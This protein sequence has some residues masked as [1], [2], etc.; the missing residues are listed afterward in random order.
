MSYRN[1]VSHFIHL[2]LVFS[3]LLLIPH[4]TLANEPDKAT[5]PNTSHVAFAG[6]GWRAHIGH[7]AWTMALLQEKDH[8]LADAFANVGT[9]SSNSGGS[10]YSTMLMFSPSFN[11]AIQQANAIEK[12]PENGA[13]ATGWLGQQKRLFEKADCPVKT[14]DL[15][16]I[17][18]FNEY[19]GGV[20]GAS[21]WHKVIANL[22]Y[23]E[24]PIDSK[25]NGQRQAW[26]ANKT[27]LLAASMLTQQAVIS[28]DGLD[29]Q[30]YQACFA[31]SKPKTRGSK[32]ARCTQSNTKAVVSPVT[33]SSLPADSQDTPLP[34]FRALKP[35]QV[36]NVGYSE[37]AY[38]LPKRA[39]TQ[40]A[41]PVQTDTLPVIVAASA[42]SAA[43]GFA[44][45]KLVS[46]SWAESLLA[47]DEAIN[48][49]VTGGLEHYDAHD[50]SVKELA[51]KKIIQ[52]ADG[53]AVDNSAVAQ[54]VAYLQHNEKGHDFNIVAFDNVQTLFKTKGGIE[55]GVDFANLFGEGVWN[56]DQICSGQNGKGDCVTTPKLQVFEKAALD[57]AKLTWQASKETSSNSAD[58]G[59]DHKKILYT[60][61]KV[62]TVENSEYGIKGGL[63]GT[64][65]AFTAAWSDANTAPKNSQQ[66]FD[67][68]AEMLSFIASG[69]QIA[70]ADGVKGIQYLQN[71]IDGDRSH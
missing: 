39:K 46:G 37:A 3:L 65:H 64:L 30:Y 32:G 23:R 18:V 62:T 21:Y 6:G 55:I 42:S 34:F 10:W 14:G 61:L 71:A 25:L 7:S 66:D 17:C 16:T 4:G 53:G 51:S 59:N 54:L 48:F 22:V 36:F 45:S 13:T 70:G 9:I 40:L 43:T 69:L 47:S 33:F 28:H 68:Y 38:F 12:W 26:A 57:N 1:L 44:A 29:E 35:E 11:D 41:N 63:T 67:A 49:Q 24:T 8:S 31:P 58:A 60:Q 15:Y 19:A 50:M 5:K 52:V 56:G 2:H 27:L 20:L